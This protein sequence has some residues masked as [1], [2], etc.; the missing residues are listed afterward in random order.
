M[1]SGQVQTS[2][3]KC[4]FEKLRNNPNVKDRFV[5]GD[6]T[7]V[8]I[9]GQFVNG[10]QDINRNYGSLTEEEREVFFQKAKDVVL[11]ERD[12][13]KEATDDDVIQAADELDRRILKAIG[14]IDAHLGIN[15][16]ASDN[17]KVL[18]NDEITRLQSN[19]DSIY[20]C[21]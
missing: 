12:F 5:D 7:I 16:T 15:G 17:T 14:F 21:Q 4:I 18:L 3:V 11:S 2:R 1:P 13:G 19:P 6:L 8:R 9:R 10:L 20:S